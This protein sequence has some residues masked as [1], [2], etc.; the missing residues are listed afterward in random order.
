VRHPNYAIVVVELAML[1]LAVGAHA[2][3]A[4]GSLANAALLVRRIQVEDAALGRTA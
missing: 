3:A 4:A 2:T 1:P